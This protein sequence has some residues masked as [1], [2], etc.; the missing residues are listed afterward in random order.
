MDFVRTFS[1]D[2][3]FYAD[4]LDDGQNLFFEIQDAGLKF[5][6]WEQN[7]LSAKLYY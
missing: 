6:Y 4:L 5:R 1:T 2:L 7:V 3:L